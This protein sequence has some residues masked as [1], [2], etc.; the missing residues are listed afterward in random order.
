MIPIVCVV[1]AIWLVMYFF[2]RLPGEAA[3]FVAKEE[4]PELYARVR[5]MA[6][7]MAVTAPESIFLVAE[8]VASLWAS[9][10][11][12]IAR[13][14]TVLYLGASLL[15]CASE[16]ELEFLIAHELAHVRHSSNASRVL[17]YWEAIGRVVYENADRVHPAL[18]FARWYVPRLTALAAARS[19]ADEYAADREAAAHASAEGAARALLRIAVLGA[20]WEQVSA[21]LWQRCYH[22]QLLPDDI[23]ERFVEAAKRATPANGRPRNAPLDTGSAHRSGM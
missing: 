15:A 14:K 10:P 8:P 12:P 22:E 20:L 18:H 6:K 19:R 3:V 16:E 13:S 23:I 7:T 11:R 5:R 9:R 17:R 2:K 21:K 4:A 1:V